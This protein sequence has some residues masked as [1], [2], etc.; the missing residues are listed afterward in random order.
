MGLQQIKNKFQD[1]YREAHLLI[2]G[3]LKSKVDK[4]W[5]TM[6][7]GGISNPLSVIEQLTARG[8]MIASTL[9]EPPFSNLHGGGP[10][11]LFAGKEKIINGIFDTL[12][13]VQSELQ[14]YA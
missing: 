9:Y 5:D 6:W 13:A 1:P 14:A 4:V 11:A 10:D 8:V 3:E 2:T 7:S 12:Q